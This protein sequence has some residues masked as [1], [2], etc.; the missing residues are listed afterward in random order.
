MIDGTGQHVW[1]STLSF[2]VQLRKLDQLIEAINLKGDC[3]DLGHT[4]VLKISH[5]NVPLVCHLLENGLPVNF[6]F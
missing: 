4:L 1:L 3:F 5:K 6:V 2:A